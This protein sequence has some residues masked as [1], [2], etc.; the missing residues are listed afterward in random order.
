LK[1]I[2]ISAPGRD[3]LHSMWPAS[4]A[5][6]LVDLSLIAIVF[7]GAV[8]VNRRIS[9]GQPSPMRLIVRL[10]VNAVAT[11]VILF[12]LAA[13]LTASGEGSATGLPLSSLR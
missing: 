8:W 13:L 4:I 11:M 9:L 1:D 6:D 2:A 12:L 5:T 10:L 7:V 3:I